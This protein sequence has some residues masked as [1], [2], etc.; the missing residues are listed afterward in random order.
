L[1]DTFVGIPVKLGK[2][3]ITQMIELKLNADEMKLLHDSSVAVKSV[4]DVYD[5]MGL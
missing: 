3:G 4:M 5:G 2:A 1:H